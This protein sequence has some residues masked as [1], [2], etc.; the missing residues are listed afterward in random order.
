[1]PVRDKDSSYDSSK[2]EGV[3]LVRDRRA[4]SASH[5]S[6]NGGFAG[7]AARINDGGTV[8]TRDA[9]TTQLILQEERTS[10]ATIRT[11]PSA[12]GG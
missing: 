7:S 4:A 12:A 10:N 9:G 5:A 11:L 2:V 8:D 1:M 3:V 6:G